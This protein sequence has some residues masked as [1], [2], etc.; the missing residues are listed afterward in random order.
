MEDNTN[1]GAIAGVVSTVLVLLAL[2]VFL[3]WRHRRGAETARQR[4]NLRTAFVRSSAY[5]VC[6]LLHSC[7]LNCCSEWIFSLVCIYDPVN[8]CG[9]AGSSSELSDRTQ[10]SFRR[11]TRSY[12]LAISAYRSTR[13]GCTRRRVAWTLLLGSARPGSGRA[14]WCI[15]ASSQEPPK[16]IPGCYLTFQ[17]TSKWQC[18]LCSG[19]RARQ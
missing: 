18:L 4:G 16:P 14:E 15:I 10:C 1:V 12:D 9:F 5:T 11:F 13:S 7:T 6:L 19:S 3:A 17:F 8:D 2:T